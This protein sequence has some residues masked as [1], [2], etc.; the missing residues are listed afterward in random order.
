MT[1]VNLTKNLQ[2]LKKQTNNKISM[3]YIKMSNKQY[4]DFRAKEQR[5]FY[6]SSSS[7]SSRID[8]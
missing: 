6:K 8:S 2:D 1:W 3:N 7:W 5:T 4:H